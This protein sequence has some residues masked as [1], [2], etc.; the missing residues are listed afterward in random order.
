MSVVT[1]D[2]IRKALSPI[3]TIVFAV[4]ILIYLNMNRKNMENNGKR[5]R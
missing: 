1:E 5:R 2:D 4:R 3:H